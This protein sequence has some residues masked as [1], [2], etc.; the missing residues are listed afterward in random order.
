MTEGLSKAYGWH[1]EC[2]ELLFTVSSH[3][4]TGYTK[5]TRCVTGEES[6]QCVR[7]VRNSLQQ[8]L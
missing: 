6:V 7:R 4:G 2:R 8:D 3:I 5:Y 1:K